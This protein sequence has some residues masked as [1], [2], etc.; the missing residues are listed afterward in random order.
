M[1]LYQWEYNNMHV[2]HLPWRQPRHPPPP[3]PSTGIQATEVVTIAAAVVTG[4]TCLIP[5][6][7]SVFLRLP[8][9][10]RY[11]VGEK[12]N[13]FSTNWLKGPWWRTSTQSMRIL[14]VRWPVWSGAWSVSVC[15]HSGSR[16]VTRAKGPRPRPRPSLPPLFRQCEY[17]GPPIGVGR[18]KNALEKWVKKTKATLFEKN[19]FP[20]PKL[21]SNYNSKTT[22]KIV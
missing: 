4:P 22:F 3:P 17:H 21:Q 10:C 11:V 20:P 19:K 16:P 7:P 14:T 18:E 13:L 9:T 2:G 1:Y 12:C 8:I 6:K 5:S 15:S